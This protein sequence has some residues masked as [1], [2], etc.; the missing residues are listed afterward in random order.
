M[1]LK[2]WWRRRGQNSSQ[3]WCLVKYI[4]M[5]LMIV[6][7]ATPASAQVDQL[8]RGLSKPGSGSSG[9]TDGKI[10]DGL[11]QALQ[12]GT[13][14]A[15]GI[16]GKADGYFKNQAIKIVMPDRLRTVER[17]LR[18][19]GQGAQIDEFVLSM[20]RA[21]ERAAPAAKSIFWDAIA[22]MGIDDARRILDGGN[23][24]AT[25]YF[26]GKT[27]DKLTTA[28]TPVVSKAMN[29]VGVTRQYKQLTG[30]AQALP[31]GGVESF[32]LDRYVVGKALDGLFVVV[33]DEERRIRTNPA[34][35]G[36]E[37]LKDVFGR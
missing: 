37:L 4:V 9:I 13:E 14:N 25:Q 21:A 35:R 22:A 18:A 2:A 24:A 26:Q 6:C 20:N 11:K 16:T 19:V 28:F 17:G 7:F 3:A 31:F 15:V 5:A 30:G 34:A 10:G 33:G 23:T 36:T 29:D 27:T 1:G 12:V 32:D 8:L